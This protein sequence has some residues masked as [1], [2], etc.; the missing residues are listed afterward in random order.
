MSSLMLES[1]QHG[2]LLLQLPV[3][4]DAL[5]PNLLG[6]T[7]LAFLRAPK[8]LKEKRSACKTGKDETNPQFSSCIS[9]TLAGWRDGEGDCGGPESKSLNPDSTS[10]CRNSLAPPGGLQHYCVF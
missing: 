6:F 9:T 8:V 3:T 5:A 7:A 2:I 4:E 1:G 10:R